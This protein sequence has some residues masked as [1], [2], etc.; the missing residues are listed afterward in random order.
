MRLPDL[1][2]GTEVRYE[3]LTSGQVNQINQ[4]SA[5]RTAAAIQRRRVLDKSHSTGKSIDQETVVAELT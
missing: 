1:G 2:D 5:E 4:A 3:P